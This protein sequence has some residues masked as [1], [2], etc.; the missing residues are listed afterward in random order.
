M[1]KTIYKQII[2]S[3]VRAMNG[4]IGPVAIMQA[5]KVKGLKVTA[6]GDVNLQGDPV[7]KIEQLIKGYEILIGSVAV[8]IAQNAA[9]P[10]LEKNKGLKI[11]TNLQ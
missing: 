6:R 4:I 3:I 9:K 7:K 11:P 8:T 2:N 10:L 1:E 5:N